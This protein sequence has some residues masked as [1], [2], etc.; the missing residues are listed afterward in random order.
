MLTAGFVGP[1]DGMSCNHNSC[2]TT[3]RPVG[4]VEAEAAGY[5]AA[6]DDAERENAALLAVSQALMA[7]EDFEH[8]AELLLRDLARALGLAAGALWLPQ[9]DVLVAR[10]SWSGPKVDRAAFERNLRPLSVPRGRGLSGCAWEQGEPVGWATST[11]RDRVPRFQ[12]ALGGLR[13][14][15]ALTGLVGEEVLGVVEL[16]STSQAELSERLMQVLTVASHVLGAVLARWRGELQLSPLTPRE[17]EILTLAAQGLGG[18]KIAQQ[19][20]ISPATVKTHFAHIHTKLGVSHRAAAVAYVM[21]A[22]L[23]E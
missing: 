19:L 4:A 10:A 12:P 1:G 8:G 16:Y 7:C 14:N 22:G 17:R 20:S 11:A 3:P 2:K 21:R 5:E 13:A 15:V 23:V 18:R 9:E 6:L